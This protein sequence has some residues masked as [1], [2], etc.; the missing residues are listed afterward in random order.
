MANGHGRWFRNNKAHLGGN[1]GAAIDGTIGIRRSQLAASD[2][3]VKK[4]KM[5]FHLVR[6]HLPSIATVFDALSFILR[7]R[8]VVDLAGNA[9]TGREISPLGA[10]DILVDASF[11]EADRLGKAIVDMVAHHYHHLCVYHGAAIVAG[12]QQQ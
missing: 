12:Q 3:R 8:R 10:V 4:G 5:A 2:C 1:D 11:A 7:G 9:K 6:N